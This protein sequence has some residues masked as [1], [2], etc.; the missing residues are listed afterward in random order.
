MRIG[1]TGDSLPV[2]DSMKYQTEFRNPSHVR[3]LS[4]ELAR[5]CQ[6][7]WKIMEVCG[8]QTHTI[9]RYAL[10]TM[11]PPQLELV[12]GPGC[13]VCVT[14]L[15][16]IEAARSI[17]L[18]HNA[19]LCSFGDML[20]VPGRAGDLLDARSRG[21]DV[22]VVQSPLEAVAIAQATPDRDVVFFGVGFETTAPATA[23]A[24]DL[25]CRNRLDNFS[26]LASHVRVPPAIELIL[27]APNCRIDGFLAAGHVCT[28]AGTREY[29]DI[30]ERF[31]APIVVTGFEPVDILYGL[32]GCVEQLEAGNAHVENRYRRSASADGNPIA[33]Q[34]ID[35]VYRIIDAPWRGM[36]V[37]P[38]GGLA[39]RDA[40]ARVDAV[41]RYGIDL[42]AVPEPTQCQAAEVLTGRIKP[43]EC[44]AFGTTC[45]PETPLGAPMVSTEGACA[46]YYQHRRISTHLQTSRTRTNSIANAPGNAS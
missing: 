6:G 17:C 32:L 18:H 27:A 11:L 16:I 2:E 10:E 31:T 23:M 12:H 45:T 20:R 41:R 39:F 25:A 4:A 9:A 26:L 37:V 5:R 13:P 3:A 15:A 21:A 33:Q 43:P 30:V 8:G 38:R 28:I 36:G 44:S 14:P 19:I 35:R 40:Y 1:A 42:S 7:H 24:A 34:M 46:A 29:P 22:R